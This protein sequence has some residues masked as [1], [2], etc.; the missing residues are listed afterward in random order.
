MVEAPVSSSV[1]VHGSVL[2]ESVL[3]VSVAR[4]IVTSDMCRK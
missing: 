3:V 2:D 1:T 4:S